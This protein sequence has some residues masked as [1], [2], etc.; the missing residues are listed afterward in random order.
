MSLPYSVCAHTWLRLIRLKI[1]TFA[2]LSVL[3]F[4]YMY[5]NI[6]LQIQSRKWSNGLVKCLLRL[7]YW[8]TIYSKIWLNGTE[9]E[10]EAFATVNNKDGGG[11]WTFAVFLFTRTS[12]LLFISLISGSSS[13]FVCVTTY[14]RVIQWNLCIKTTLTRNKLWSLNM[15]FICR[16]NNMESV[17][18]GTCKMW[19]L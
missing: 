9:Q 7:L 2:I 8:A 13:Y 12:L 14:S 4:I 15:V 11:H 3:T 1:Y 18:L 16:F 10:I 19:S 17:P 6:N 5:H